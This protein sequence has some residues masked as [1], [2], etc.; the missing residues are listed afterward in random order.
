[1][2][3]NKKDTKVSNNVEKSKDDQNTK[4]INSEPEINPKLIELLE[5]YDNF[6]NHLDYRNYLYYGALFQQLFKDISTDEEDG[7]VN[8]SIDE[9]AKLI[10]KACNKL[11]FDIHNASIKQIFKLYTVLIEKLGGSKKIRNYDAERMEQLLHRMYSDEEVLEILEELE[12]LSINPENIEGINQIDEIIFSNGKTHK[13]LPS[14]KCDEL[15][16][17]YAEINSSK[18]KKKEDSNKV[19]EITDK[20]I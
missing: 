7:K 16:E 4:V 10:E 8:R 14:S 12:E 11:K 6:M 13:L 2:S 19:K 18:M 3:S 5:K 17:F 15:V 9:L 1:M 20:N